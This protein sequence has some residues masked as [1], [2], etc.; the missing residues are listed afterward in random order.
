[1]TF[2]RLIVCA[3]LALVF[4]RPAVGAENP[5]RLE[6][7]VI[8]V[9]TPGTV[10]PGYF[11]SYDPHPGYAIP[12][13]FVRQTLQVDPLAGRGVLA[14]LDLPI[15]PTFG[16]RLSAGRDQNPFGGLNTP[17][18]MTYKYTYWAP[19]AGPSQYAD[20]VVHTTTEWPETSGALRRASL[21]LEATVRL[22]LGSAVEARLTAGPLLS[23]L[24]GEIDSFEYTEL[25]YER[26]GATFFHSYFVHLR[27]PVR[28]VL[29]ATAGAEISVRL[30]PA[31]ALRLRG[32]WRGGS[33]EGTPE[34][35]A[36]YD[37][38][39]GLYP[40]AATLVRIKSKIIPGPIVL[41]PSPFTF[42]AGLA[43]TFR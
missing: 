18:E 11:H 17:V 10:G 38:A 28:S 4:A 7:S 25:T 43:L 1:M 39:S 9:L 21:A 26:Y 37:Y 30:S 41:S 15:G 2:R 6:F 19:W 36:V 27:L 3:A 42:G 29:S 23:W 24:E 16:L 40:D 13:S 31:L 22:P 35:D 32:A 33:Y 8:G 14:A 34:V 20:A 5:P 12:G